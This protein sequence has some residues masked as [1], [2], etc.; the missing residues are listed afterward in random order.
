[1]NDAEQVARAA[2]RATKNA[3]TGGEVEQ[4]T[5]FL[6]GTWVRVAAVVL[7]I[8]T[9]AFVGMRAGTGTAL[10]MLAGAAL[11]LVILFAFRSVQAAFEPA[12]DLVSLAAKTTTAEA[13][14]KTALKA[15]KD[16]EYERALGNVADEDYKKLLDAYR[17]EAKLALRAVD[18][19]RQIRR[20]AASA[21]I[22]EH[23]TAEQTSP[24]DEDE[25]RGE[26]PTP[27]PAEAPV[28]KRND[29]S[30]TPTASDKVMSK[31]PKKGTEDSVFG[32]QH[33]CPK[34][35]TNNEPD[36]KFC[37]ECATAM[38]RGES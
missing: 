35:D 11:L 30:S 17:E 21:W 29:R 9:V 37:K 22:A 34:C 3:G 33:R 13:W 2:P 23:L 15:I 1:M 20:E 12:E 6:Q 7:V 18:D 31:T 38:P 5:P 8:L 32:D 36:A 25:E 14:K 19:E 4:I 24:S 28:S 16:L 26:D 27:T 10:I